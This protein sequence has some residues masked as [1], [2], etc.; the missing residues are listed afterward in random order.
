MR[1]GG[2][3]ENI[4]RQAGLKKLYGNIFGNCKGG[5]WEAEHY[6][7]AIMMLSVLE[8]RLFGAVARA[9]LFVAALLLLFSL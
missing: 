7:V 4:L 2:V 5:E 6:Y 9:L 1:N 8:S 3:R